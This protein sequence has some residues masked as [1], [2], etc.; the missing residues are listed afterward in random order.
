MAWVI[1]NIISFAV[2]FAI[3]YFDN[4]LI[5]WVDKKGN[6]ALRFALIIPP[7]YLITNLTARILLYVLF[8]WQ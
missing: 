8:R 4:P 1:S 6:Y 2:L 5:K 3:A 7:L